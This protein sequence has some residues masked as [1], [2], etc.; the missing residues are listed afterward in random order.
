MDEKTYKIFL[1]IFYIFSFINYSISEEKQYFPKCGVYEEKFTPIVLKGIPLSKNSSSIKRGLDSEKYFKDFNIYLDLKNLDIEIEQNNLNK[2]REIYI[3]S[4][5]KAINT[6][7]KLLKVVPFETNLQILDEDLED[8]GLVSWDKTKVGTEAY[9][10]GISIPS[11]GIDLIIFGKI[12]DVNPSTLASAGPRYLD[13]NNRP[14]IGIVNINKNVDYSLDKS[15]EYL[16]SII[17]H[18]FTHILGFA[19]NFFVNYFH[20]VYWEVDTYGVN[21]AYINSSKVLEV[22]KKYYNCND[23][24][25]VA[26]EEYGGSGTVGSHWEAKI[27]LGDYMNGVIYTNEQV[28]SE[29]TLALLEDSGFYKANYYTGGLMRYGKHKGCSFVKESCV[30][31]KNHTINPLF[32]NEFYDQIHSDYQ[33]DSSCS[34]GRQSRTYYAWRLYYNLQTNYPYYV[35]F[36]NPNYGG[37][38]PADFCPVAQ[39]ISNE[40][41]TAHYTGQCNKKG[42]GG[43]GLIYIIQMVKYILVK[44]YRVLLEKLIQKNHFVF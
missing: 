26:L 18:E 24:K 41:T 43:Y 35:Y 4:M 23:L 10:N 40:E 36:E 32:E 19:N 29:F 30:D 25:G 39:S 14:F 28:I 21:R 22:A 33:R 17:I 8:I 31:R 1:F 3:S 9:N 37:F 20:N 27:L 16:E 34:S 15:R 38:G 2:Y 13:T 44:V 11:L 42:N 6:L 12:M 7:T 5:T